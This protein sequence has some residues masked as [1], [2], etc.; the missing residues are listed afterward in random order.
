MDVLFRLDHQPST[1]REL[2]F[3]LRQICWVEDHSLKYDHHALFRKHFAR[4]LQLKARTLRRAAHLR[5]C[6][7]VFERKP[8]K[9][10]GFSPAAVADHDF[11]EV[12]LSIRNEE[13]HSLW[14][15]PTDLRN[16]ERLPETFVYKAVGSRDNMCYAIRRLAACRLSEDAIRVAMQPWVQITQN[17]PNM[18]NALD[19]FSS[20]EFG[21]GGGTLFYL[22][23][24][25]LRSSVT[26]PISCST[27]LR[28]RVPPL[29]CEFSRTLFRQEATGDYRGHALELC[30]PNLIVRSII[31]PEEVLGIGTHA[32]CVFP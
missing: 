23:L 5:V 3:E 30:V 31:L 6:K 14:L 13:F 11:F 22:A 21:D 8:A 25:P 12:P 28:L 19:V 29:C 7:S 27:L 2:L 15:L 26:H 20:S 24:A 9:N 18:V 32:G 4:S 17:H 16:K 10:E 1:Q